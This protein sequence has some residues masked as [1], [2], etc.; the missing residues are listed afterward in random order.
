MIQ[1]LI[2][3]TNCYSIRWSNDTDTNS[4]P[5]K[6]ELPFVFQFH[7]LFTIFQTGN[8]HSQRFPRKTSINTR[9]RRKEGKKKES[10]EGFSWATSVVTGEPGLSRLMWQRRK[11]AKTFRESFLSFPLPFSPP[12]KEDVAC[13]LGRTSSVPTK[14]RAGYRNGG[15]EALSENRVSRE[16]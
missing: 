12:R 6:L 15:R 16:T 3:E 8:F 5:V 7:R 14:F 10:I 13:I 11:E 1:N 4:I 2:L 9:E